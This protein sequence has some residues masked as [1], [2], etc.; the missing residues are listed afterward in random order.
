MAR[1]ELKYKGRGDFVF[2]LYHAEYCEK[3]AACE[4]RIDRVQRPVTDVNGVTGIAYAKVVTPRSV[5]LT[6]GGPSVTV[7]HTALELQQV[8]DAL[9]EGRIEF[10]EENTAVEPA[11]A[12]AEE[13]V[14][15]PRSRRR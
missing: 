1:I 11:D 12:L 2:T 4:C 10:K 13:A 3:A 7:S 15:G 5:Y 9:R 6:G 14:A 8:R